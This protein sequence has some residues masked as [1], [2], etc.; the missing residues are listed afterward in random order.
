MRDASLAAPRVWKLPD[1]WTPR[2]RPQVFAKPQTVSHSSHTPPRRVPRR[3]ERKTRTS[4]FA[5]SATHRF[6]GGGRRRSDHERRCVSRARGKIPCERTIGGAVNGWTVE[7]RARQSQAIQTWRPWDK[8]TGPRSRSGKARSARNADHGRRWRERRATF[9][10][11]HASLR[12]YA[13]ALDA[14]VRA[15]ALPK[16]K[17]SG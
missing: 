7:R 4:Q 17:S 13:S 12:R 14:L 2:T 3:Q 15:V 8:A 5:G 16:L 6:C 11:V 1:L 9:P 10:A